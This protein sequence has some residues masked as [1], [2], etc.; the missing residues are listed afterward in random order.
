MANKIIP[1]TL[2]GKAYD[3]VDDLVNIDGYDFSRAIDTVSEN[4]ELTED[5][6]SELYRT[7]YENNNNGIA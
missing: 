1:K 5:Q 3:S 4:Y 2:I 6:E 7:W